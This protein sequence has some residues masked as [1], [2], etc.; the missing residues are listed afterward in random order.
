[1]K[2]NTALLKLVPPQA[3]VAASQNLVPHL[4]HRNHIY[5]VW[6][7]QHG[8]DWWFDFVGEPEYLVA[9]LRHDQWITQLLESPENFLMAITNM[10]RQEI[11]T[12]EKQVGD[13]VLF[14]I[15]YNNSA[16]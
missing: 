15:N 10:E 3:S 8:K 6:P 5:L 12:R 16:R 7:R 11:L 14:R 9:D 4:T 1:M 2:N 13:A